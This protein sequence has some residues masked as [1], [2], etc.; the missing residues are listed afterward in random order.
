MEYKDK[1]ELQWQAALQKHY[2]PEL[3]EGGLAEKIKQE[4]R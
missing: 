4:T 3:K 2:E 1:E